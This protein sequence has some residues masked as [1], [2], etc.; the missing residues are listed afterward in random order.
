[1]CFVR[2]SE[3]Q[4][5]FPYQTLTETECVYCAVRTERLNIIPFKFRLQRVTNMSNVRIVNWRRIILNRKNGRSGRNRATDGNFAWEDGRLQSYEEL[6]SGRPATHW[7][8]SRNCYPNL[9]QLNHPSQKLPPPEGMERSG[10]IAPRTFVLS[11]RC[12]RLASRSGHFTSEE[13]FPGAHRIGNYLI[14]HKRF[15]RFRGA[16]NVLFLSRIEPCF[17]SRLSRSLVT[18]YRLGFPVSFQM[19]IYLPFMIIVPSHTT[20]AVVRRV[21]K[22]KR[23]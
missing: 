20:S 6:H 16:M 17:L 15:R 18:T 1:M 23:K 19:L 21:F 11:T 4:G 10:S 13:T 5:L 3:K 7:R 14:P 8:S 12:Q 22:S 9:V 2:I